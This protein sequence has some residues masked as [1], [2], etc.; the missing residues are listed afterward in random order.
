[1]FSGTLL[2]FQW[3][4]G[5]WQFDLWFLCLFWNQLEHLKFTVHVSC[6]GE[7]KSIILQ[8]LRLRYLG[9]DQGLSSWNQAVE[10]YCDLIWWLG[11]SSKF[12]GF[13]WVS[14]SCGLKSEVHLF[15][16]VI[17]GTA[18]RSQRQAGWPQVLAMGSSLSHFKVSK[19]LSAWISLTSFKGSPD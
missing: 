19:S 18:L 6:L 1:M 16:W 8:L 15:F 17:T 3:S 10:N 4:S 2:L 14:V 5:Y 13:W 9:M 7:H 12:T 11:S